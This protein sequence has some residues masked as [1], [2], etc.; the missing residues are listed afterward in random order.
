MNQ[1]DNIRPPDSVIR[2]RLIHDINAPN[3]YAPNDYALK[4]A[5]KI[6]LKELKMKEE[7]ETLNVIC[8]ELREQEQRERENKFTNTKTQLKKLIL[9]DKDNVHYYE[10]ILSVIEMYEQGLIQHYSVDKTEYTNI[11]STLKSIR[12]PSSEV[13]ELTK[14]IIVSS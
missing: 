5:L 8:N 4:K 9:F 3:D 7:E 12:L 2:E 13:N 6:S 1:D 10:I 14:L 11:V